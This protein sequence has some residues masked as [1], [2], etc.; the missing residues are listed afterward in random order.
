MKVHQW[1]PVACARGFWSVALG[2]QLNLSSL[3]V[4]H[5]FG[6]WHLRLHRGRG[7]PGVQQHWDCRAWLPDVFRLDANETAHLAL[8]YRLVPAALCFQKAHIFSRWGLCLARDEPSKRLW[9][10]I[11]SKNN[12]LI[13]ISHLAHGALVGLDEALSRGGLRVTLAR[14]AGAA[15]RRAPRG[16]GDGQHQQRE[17]HVDYAPHLQQGTVVS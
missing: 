13:Q 3:F 6:L 17:G 10:V 16:G 11:P 4:Y 9:T 1:A 14:L 12:L 15:L 8:G 2:L 5:A 7:D